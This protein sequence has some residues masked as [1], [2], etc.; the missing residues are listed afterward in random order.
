MP[1]KNK[2]P[3][4]LMRALNEIFKSMGTPKQSYSDEEGSFRALYF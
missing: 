1:I 2:Q 3:P 4:E